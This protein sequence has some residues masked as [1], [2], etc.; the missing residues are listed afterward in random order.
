MPLRRL[1]RTRFG[2]CGVAAAVSL[3]KRLSRAATSVLQI[4]VWFMRLL[5]VSVYPEGNVIDLG[6]YKLQVAEARAGLNYLFPLLAI[7]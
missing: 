2:P 3:P 6:V 4:G 5:G 1:I 7:G